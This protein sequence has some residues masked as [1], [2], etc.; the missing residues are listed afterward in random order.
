MATSE[1]VHDLL[2]RATRLMDERRTTE[3]AKVLRLAA[4]KEPSDPTV[5]MRLAVALWQGEHRADEALVILERLTAAWP[6]N[7][8]AHCVTAQVLNSLGHGRQAAAAAERA[9]EEDPCLSAAFIELVH[10]QAHGAASDRNLI[11]R[12][13]KTLELPQL[14]AH[15]RRY[16][17]LAIGRAL[18]RSGADREAFDAFQEAQ[19]VAGGTL[20]TLIPWS[21]TGE[22]RATQSLMEMFTP[23]LLAEY[24][25]RGDP[26]ERMIF[27]IGMPRSGTTLLARMLT[28]HSGVVSVDETTAIGDLWR[29][30]LSDHFHRRVDLNAALDGG[31]LKGAAREYFAMI[32]PRLRLGLAGGSRVVDKMNTNFKLA[33]LLVLLFPRARILLMRRHPLDVG[34]S[35]FKGSFKYAYT[36]GLA[37]MGEAYRVYAEL[38]DHWCEVLGERVLTIQYEQLVASPSVEIARVLSHCGL[39]FEPACAFPPPEGGLVLTASVAQVRRPI[40]TKSVARW[41]AVE[42]QLAPMIEA[43]GGMPWIEAQ[44]ARVWAKSQHGRPSAG[45]G[46]GGQAELA[47]S[48]QR[49][50]DSPSWLSPGLEGGMRQCMRMP[51]LIVLL[52][53]G[54]MLCACEL[55]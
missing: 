16:L 27:V 39:A 50:V 49:N 45:A 9:L 47:A 3:A 29:A 55:L 48:P 44:Q 41:R 1:S 26:D 25:G 40:D 34:L 20:G 19:A 43:M 35:S 53:C 52:L 21:V 31:L 8:V 17:L 36:R 42:A 22:R 30:G 33:P 7:A 46:K 54:C 2:S 5:Q 14:S 15:S 13:R 24:G 6:G 28:A 38:M 51:L 10:A 12:M 32:A 11:D 23:R 18:E 4:I 37:S